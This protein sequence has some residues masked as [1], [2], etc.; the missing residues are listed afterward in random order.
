MLQALIGP[1]TGLL[2]KFIEDKDQKNKL[3]HDLAT[4]ADNHA[5][6][7]A[8]GQLAINAE[9]AKSR[10]LFVSGWRPSVGW[11]CSLAL[12]AHFLVFPT[13]D[14]VT[15]YMGIEAVPYP[16]FDMDSLMTVLLGLLG[17]GGMRSYEK[18]KGLTK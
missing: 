14:V 5:Q 15:A 10:N 6:E 13:M 7:L 11:C 4:M 2:D 12:F 1:V 3:A 17:L 16:A 9:E 18:S 8:K